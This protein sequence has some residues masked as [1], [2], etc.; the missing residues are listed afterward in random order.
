MRVHLGNKVGMSF[1]GEFKD[2]MKH[3]SGYIV[4]SNLDIIYCEVIND[5]LSGI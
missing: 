4:D 3:G 1:V 5:E 2:G